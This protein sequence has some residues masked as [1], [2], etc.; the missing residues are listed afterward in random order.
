MTIIINI[1]AGAFR[2]SEEILELV[3]NNLNWL[4][5]LII[6]CYI[7]DGSIKLLTNIWKSGVYL[8]NHEYKYY[9]ILTA[10]LLTFLICS[11]SPWI[12][13]VLNAML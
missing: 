13:N 8:K 9:V 5:K 4:Q 7:I 2:L 6:I 12:Y 10:M 3:T 1:G 11:C